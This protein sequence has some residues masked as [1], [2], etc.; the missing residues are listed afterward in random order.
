MDSPR[1][2]QR[3]LIWYLTSV[4]LVRG[5]TW[6]EFN[7]GDV[8][9][10][11]VS[12]PPDPHRFRLGQHM[13]KML[14]AWIEQ[15]DNYTLI[16]HNLQVFEGQRTVGEFDFLVQVENGDIEHWEAAIKFYLGTGDRTIAA[17]WYG[18]NTTDRLDKKLARLDQ[19]QLRL[20]DHPAA[21]ALLH[22][23][24]IRIARSRCLMKGRLFHPWD[25][26][27]I[28]PDSINPSHEHGWWLTKSAFPSTLASTDNRFV[29]L[30]KSLWLAPLEV[31]DATTV[32]DA[33]E[34]TTMLD[35]DTT[36][37]ATHLAVLND[38]G[39]INRGFVVDD[40]WLART[41]AP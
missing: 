1:R 41:A 10:T 26:E 23:L 35:R 27:R 8:S 34:L 29:Y 40:R 17:N 21:R 25:S 39:E 36:E 20:G 13:E 12:P 16:D 11:A 33:N 5:E 30:P 18:P 24:G 7:E 9:D 22:D 28:Q 2:L 38:K 19:H 6:S 3:D 15:S 37:Q 32:M 14:Q 4:A 31:D